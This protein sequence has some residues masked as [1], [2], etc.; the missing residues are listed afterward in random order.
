VRGWLGRLARTIVAAIRRHRHRHGRR[1]HSECD[2]AP[3]SSFFVTIGNF[4]AVELMRNPLLPY[5]K[6]SGSVL[7]NFNIVEND[8]GHALWE[9]TRINEKHTAEI[10]LGQIRSFTALVHMFEQLAN[11]RFTDKATRAKIKRLAARM[12]VAN[13]PMMTTEMSAAMDRIEPEAAGKGAATHGAESTEGSAGS[14]GIWP[15]FTA[16]YHAAGLGIAKPLR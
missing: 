7:V 4:G 8:L 10:V 9:L 15:G 3:S 13:E 2:A 16:H 1:H 5:Y 14:G 12:K 6:V 11:Q